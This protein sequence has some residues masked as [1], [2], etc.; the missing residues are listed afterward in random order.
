[1]SPST[2]LDVREPIARLS[3]HVPAGLPYRI[4]SEIS[5]GGSAVVYRAQH[6]GLGRRVALKVPLAPQPTALELRRFVR[7]YQV[8]SAIRHPNIVRVYDGGEVN[9]SFYLAMEHLEGEPL[10]CLVRREAAVPAR[11]VASLVRQ[12]AS[13]I[14]ACHAHGVVHRDVKPANVVVGRDDRATLIDLGLAWREGGERMTSKQ[15]V[16]GTPRYLAPEAV[17]GANAGPPAD[18]YAIGLVLH[19]LLS[20]SP[21]FPT[22]PLGELLSQIVSCGP[23]PLRTVWPA[24]RML[25]DLVHDMSAPDPARRPTAAEVAE[26][27]ESLLESRRPWTGMSPSGRQR[28]PHSRPTRTHPTLALAPVSQPRTA[29]TAVLRR[30]KRGVAAALAAVAALLILCV[31]QRCFPFAGGP[32]PGGQRGERAAPALTAR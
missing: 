24:P 2:S 4:E 28:I 13:A 1:M 21:A 16:L 7:E 10:E 25:L 17:V 14:A 22:L 18:V 9:G 12:V 20:G 19:E 29:N 11:R 31:I 26:R 5:R 30:R 6:R 32:A 27:L 8:L 15:H 23:V 3:S